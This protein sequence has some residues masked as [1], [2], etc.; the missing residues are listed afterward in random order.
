MKRVACLLLS[1]F[2]PALGLAAEPHVQES[3][4][5]IGTIR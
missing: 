1:L 3:M 5:V 4:V 2:I